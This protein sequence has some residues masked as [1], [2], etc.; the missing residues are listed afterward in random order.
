MR[1]PYTEPD[2]ASIANA[3]RELLD[4]PRAP[5]LARGS[6]ID[7]VSPVQL[8]GRAHIHLATYERA[9]GARASRG[10]RSLPASASEKL[11]VVRGHLRP[12]PVLSN[13]FWIRCSTPLPVHLTSCSPPTEGGG[14]PAVREGGGGR[15]GAAEWPQRSVMDDGGGCH[16]PEFVVVANPDAGTGTRL[17]RRAVGCDG[18]LAT[19]SELRPA[20][21]HPGGDGVTV[22]ARAAFARPRHRACAVRLVVAGQSL[23]AAYRRERGTGRGRPAGCLARACWC[24][25]PRST[26]RRLRPRLL[27]VLRGHRS[28]GAAGP[29]R[30]AERLRAVRRRRAHRR[31]ATERD[32]RRMLAEH[33]R[34]AWRYLSRRYAGWRWAPVRWVLRIGLA[35]RAFLAMRSP[36]VAAG[37][38][39]QQRT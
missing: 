36:R 19:R 13:L 32:K 9:C 2:P 25:V 14:A 20:D 6:R 23:D 38:A 12:R 24:A 3:L 16:R 37:A 5:R 1:S 39:P 8:A 22:G 26:G 31:D 4:A 28:G 11:A 21:P 10:W 34:S 29:G 7:P 15:A 17:A 18:A 33:H 30:L 35:A 27:H